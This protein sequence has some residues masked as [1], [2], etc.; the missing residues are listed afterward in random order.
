VEVGHAAHTVAS[1]GKNNIRGEDLDNDAGHL[2]I[3]APTLN[4]AVTPTSVDKRKTRPS[5][6]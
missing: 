5:R 2:M 1:Q 6:G 4:A 3:G